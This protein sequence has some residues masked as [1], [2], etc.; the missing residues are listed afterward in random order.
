MS[1]YLITIRVTNL[2]PVNSEEGD[3]DTSPGYLGMA[4]L[5]AR[6]A[7]NEALSDKSLSV[8]HLPEVTRA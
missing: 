4:A 2:N 6:R 8:I 7:V 5:A 1:D 3:N